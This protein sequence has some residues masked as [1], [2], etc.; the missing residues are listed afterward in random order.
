MRILVWSLRIILFLLLLAFLSRN[1]G[2]VNLSFFFGSQW[3]I[4][5][6]LVM[7][8]FFAAGAL[9]GSTAAVVTLFKQRREIGRLQK[10]AGATDGARRETPAITNS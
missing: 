4:P 2:A 3:T 8:I 5:L 10:R 9:L 6:S 1:S 7:L